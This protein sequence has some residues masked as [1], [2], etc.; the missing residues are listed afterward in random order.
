MHRLITARSAAVRATLP[1]L[2]PAGQVFARALLARDGFGHHALFAYGDAVAEYGDGLAAELVA[3]WRIYGPLM[4]RR[5]RCPEYRAA[6]L[7][8]VLR[9]GRAE[10]EAVGWLRSLTDPGVPVMVATSTAILL[11]R[12]LS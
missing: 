3:R 7:T 2:S 5:W 4:W 10:A 9:M 6:P 8:D 11:W 12:V 1:A